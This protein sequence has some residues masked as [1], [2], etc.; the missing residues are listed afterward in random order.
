MMAMLILMLFLDDGGELGRGHLEAAV[1]GDDPDF[2]VRAGELCADGRGQREAH[3]AQAAGGDQRARLLVVVVLRLPHLVLAHVGDHDGVAAG[4]APDVV[5]DVRR[6]EVAGVGQV[7]DV[8]HRRRRPC[9]LR[10]S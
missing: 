8:A 4:D 2:L 9:W 3:G 5:N 10:W 6:V 1:A 7:L